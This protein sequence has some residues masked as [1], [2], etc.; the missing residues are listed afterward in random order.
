MKIAI[1]YRSHTGTTRRY[2]EAIGAYLI[3]KGH[4]VVVSSVGECDVRALRTFDAVLLGC[5]TQGW[6]V[7]RQH[8]DAPWIAFAR[9]LPK[10]NGTR[11]GLF[12]T[13]TLATGS[14]FTRMR[15]QLVG[16]SATATLELKSRDGGMSEHDRQALDRFLG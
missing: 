10:L 1:V 7:V 14:M 15:E 11:V 12:T 16:T 6:F 2:A 13:Y 5:W 3:G 4:E 9:E 8:P